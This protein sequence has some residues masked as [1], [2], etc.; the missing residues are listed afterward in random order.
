V[1]K[2][3]CVKRCASDA[4]VSSGGSWSIRGGD[5]S[6]LGGE[7]GAGDFD[8]LECVAAIDIPFDGTFASSFAAATPAY[9]LE[10]T[11]ELW[12]KAGRN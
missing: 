3:A 11:L 6:Q 10:A 12:R 5:R 2:I 8:G 9:K 1:Q 4:F 7:P